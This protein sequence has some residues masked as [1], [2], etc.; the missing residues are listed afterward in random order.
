MRNF[1][2]L[3]GIPLTDPNGRWVLEGGT[4][5]RIIPSRPSSGATLPGRDGV[6]PSFGSRFDPGGVGLRIA[7]LGAD[8][9]SMLRSVE[10]LAGVIGQRYSL[11]PLVHDYG[12]GERREALIEV[13]ASSKPE[14][15]AFRNAIIEVQC[16]VPGAFWRDPSLSNSSVLLP[17]SPAVVE[18]DALSGSTGTINDA[19]LRFEGGFSEAT[20]EDAVSGDS[21]SVHGPVAAGEYV[22]V[23]TARWIARRHTTDSWSTS[24]GSNWITKVE[25]NRGSGPM[26][27]LN[28]DFALG[29]GRI[30]IRAAGSG[31]T[32]S[33]K[34][35]IRAKRSFL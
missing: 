14:V 21:I 5:L 10:L 8:Y 16:S 28:P 19:I 11:L 34:V 20:V 13:T 12:D 29:R 3:G 35:I 26:L 2:T 6:L 30:R 9:P 27:A 22:V 17:A 18:V 31:I 33:P 24:A 15:V 25:S 1:Y 23:D 4:G 32:G 7:V